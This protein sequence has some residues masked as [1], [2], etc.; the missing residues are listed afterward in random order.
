MKVRFC[1]RGGQGI[2]MLG[3]V[4]GK[5]ASRRFHVLQNQV[6]GAEARLGTC[7]SEVIVS[8]EPI[9]ELEVKDVDFVVAMSR[10][11]Y[12]KYSSDARHAI[13][14]ETL[15]ISGKKTTVVPAKR[16]SNE[17]FGRPLFANMIMLG[18]LV[19]KEG[20]ISKEDVLGALA[21]TF[22]GERLEKNIK[23]FEVGMKLYSAKS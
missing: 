21:E 10:Q 19:A 11:A 13:V 3:I 8:E 4:F 23:A 9:Y 15:D 18:Y 12:D 22:S 17:I 2:I 5:A 14:D 7:K 16:L 20:M 6:Y 1:G